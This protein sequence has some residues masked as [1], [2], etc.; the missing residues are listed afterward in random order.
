MKSYQIHMIRHGLTAENRKGAYIGST[1]VPLSGEGIRRLK[2]YGT[3]FVYPGAAVLYTSPLQRC[4]QTCS[5][6]YPAMQPPFVPGLAEYDFGVWEGK[7]AEQLKGE[8]SFQ[9]WLANSADLA[10]PGGESGAQFTKRICLAFENMVT[11]LIKTGETSA[12]LVTHGGVIMTL[13]SVYGLP[14]AKPYDW[15]MDN[16]F[17]YSLRITPLLWMRDKVAEVYARIP[18]EKQNDI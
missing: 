17:G 16:G 8:E 2:H 15:R 1:D 9:T 4:I 18:A 6:L 7:T 12:V 13:L 14:H 11:N 3:A 5:I 10:P